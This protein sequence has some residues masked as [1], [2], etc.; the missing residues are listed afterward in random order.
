MLWKTSLAYE[1]R[2]TLCCLASPYASPYT[3][4]NYSCCNY[5]NARIHMNTT[6]SWPTTMWQPAMVMVHI[7]R[8][9]QI[10]PK[11][12]ETDLWLLWNANRN[13]GFPIQ[14]LPSDS[15]SEVRFHHFGCFRVSTSPIQKKWAEWASEWISGSSHQS[16]P[17]WALW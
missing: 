6:C 17:H 5:T 14:N 11:L 7:V 9:M 3:S 13:L 1:P 10:S 12:S 4:P 15:Q 2:G 16:A 8:H